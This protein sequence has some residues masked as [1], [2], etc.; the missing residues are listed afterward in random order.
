[1]TILLLPFAL[2]VNLGLSAV[3]VWLAHRADQKTYNEGFD[4]GYAAGLR[5]QKHHTL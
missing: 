2:T 5:A 3:A 1:M 4:D